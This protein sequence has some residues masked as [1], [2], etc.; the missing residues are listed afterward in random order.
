MPESS[1]SLSNHRFG[2]NKIDKSDV[3]NCP[4]SSACSS[5][6][7]VFTTT[8][9]TITK[10]SLFIPSRDN[11][12]QSI[13]T[14]TSLVGQ[15]FKIKQWKISKTKKKLVIQKDASKS[16]WGAFL[17]VNWGEMVRKV[18]ELTYKCSGIN[19][20]QVCDSNIH[21]KTIKYSNSLADRQQDCTFISFENG[22]RGGGTHNR[23]LLYISKFI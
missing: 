18:G 1:F 3:L 22:G 11:I 6:A 19:S 8:T 16:G 15:N 7:K 10:P 2:I 9:N 21:K 17:G 12:K 4:S 23:E 13:E 5:T 20:S 14:G